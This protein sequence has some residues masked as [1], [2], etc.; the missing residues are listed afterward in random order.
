MEFSKNSWHYRLVKRNTFYF[1][2]RTT[3]D[4]CSYTWMV[5]Q[6]VIKRAVFLLLMTILAV[7]GVGCEGAVLGW[8]VAGV[9]HG[10]VILYS[11]HSLLDFIVLVTAAL[12]FSVIAAV[13]MAF[14][15]DLLSNWVR[16]MK[17]RMRVKRQEALDS[18]VEPGLF[19]SWHKS[20]KS[21]TCNIIT[22]K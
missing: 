10:F 6:Q 14:G 4:I 20:V 18:N 7:I 16:N 2:S 12:D 8:L 19:A 21:K 5:I 17:Y 3:Y 9:F 15:V 1:E 22:F 11:E 13:G